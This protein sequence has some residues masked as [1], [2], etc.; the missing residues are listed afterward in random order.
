MNFFRT[1]ACLFAIL[2]GSVSR[3]P[4]EVPAEWQPRIVGGGNA[5]VAVTAPADLRFAHLSWPKAVRAADGTI[6]LAYTAGIFHG[7]HGGGSPAVS[8]STDDGR[9]FSAPNVLREFGPDKDYTQSGNLAIG[10]ADD[11]ALVLLAMAYTGGTGKIVGTAGRGNNIYGWRSTDSGRTWTPTDTSKL[12]PNITGSVF[13]RVIDVSGQ[14]LTVLG[15]YRAPSKPDTGIWLAQSKDQ[16]RS[17]GEPRMI[18]DVAA[19]EP[20]LVVTENRRIAFL[21]GKNAGGRQYV[22]HSDDGGKTWSTE[23][24]NLA[25]PPGHSLAAPFATQNPAN[26]KQLLVL[27]NERAGSKI[28]TPSSITLWRGEVDKL[29]WTTERKLIELP[30]SDDNP[31]KDLGYPW[32]LHKG[33]DQWQLYFYYGRSRGECAI[34]VADVTIK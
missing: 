23:L 2:I 22:A 5:R 15:H 13:G 30:K 14:G 27:T 11:G 20:V 7:D 19:A 6:V 8:I 32:L 33:G 24:S 29:E 34:W 4:G 28:T 10:S 3:A 21:R 16:G 9:T 26:P 17:W 31:N 12:G 25:P 1:L 18:T